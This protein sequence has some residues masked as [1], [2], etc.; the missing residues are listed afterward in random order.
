MHQARGLVAVASAGGHVQAGGEIA[1]GHALEHMDGPLQRPHQRTAQHAARH[2]RQHQRSQQQAAREP[3]AHGVARL[4]TLEAGLTVREARLD[5]RLQRS[6]V[7]GEQLRHLGGVEIA[8]G[9]Q[10]AALQRGDGRFE[11]GLDEAGAR[12]IGGLQPGPVGLGDGQLRE[13][14]PRLVGRIDHRVRILEQLGQLLRRGHRI[15]VGQVNARPQ[16]V[17]RVPGQQVHALG[18]FQVDGAQIGVGGTAGGDAGAAHHRDHRGKGGDQHRQASPETGVHPRPHEHF[19]LSLSVGTDRA[20][21][22]S[23]RAYPPPMLLHQDISARERRSWRASPPMSGRR[24]QRY[25]RL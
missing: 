24:R 16:Q 1:R 4:R 8:V 10:V 21:A 7:D 19:P 5:Q 14:R 22:A 11:R 15:E 25:A 2:H 9:G 20:S 17:D 13:C 12:G 6:V 3:D 23:A 18:I